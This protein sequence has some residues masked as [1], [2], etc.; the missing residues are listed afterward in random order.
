MIGRPNGGGK[1]TAGL[2]KQ[3]DSR[4]DSLLIRSKHDKGKD[5]E[6]HTHEGDVNQ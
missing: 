2:T 5:H 1:H 6:L 4:A 3:N